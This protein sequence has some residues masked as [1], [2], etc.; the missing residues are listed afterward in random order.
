[1]Y[2]R[3]AIAFVLLPLVLQ[4]FSLHASADEVYKWVDEDGVVHYSDQPVPGAEVI[5]IP[6]SNRSRPT[7][8]NTSVR[9]RAATPEPEQPAASEPFSYES[10]SFSSPSPEQTLWNIGGT[11]NVALNLTPALRAGDQV[12]LY[13][14]GEPQTISGLR[15]E[16]Q[17]VWRGTHNLQAE[18]LDE[19]G[20]LMI[21]SD[22]IRFYVQQ[23]SI[24][25]P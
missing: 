9:R 8:P 25:N 11:L 1:M 23:T 12:R 10:L 24:L 15:T 4:S 17:E 18:V 20:E 5:Q 19:N 14:D 22:P 3:P 7:R 16:L 13:F 6:D 21:R 2:R